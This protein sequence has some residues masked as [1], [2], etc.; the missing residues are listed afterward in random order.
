[1]HVAFERV[2]CKTSPAVGRFIWGNLASG[3]WVIYETLRAVKEP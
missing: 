2:R 1:M 3:V